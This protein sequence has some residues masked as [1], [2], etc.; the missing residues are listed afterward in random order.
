MEALKNVIDISTNKK[1]EMIFLSMED[2]V[3]LG[4]GKV[5]LAAH[6]IE[7]GFFLLDKNLILQPFKTTLKPA[8]K[9]H[10]HHQG[11]VNFLPAY[12][13][14]PE[15]E[16]YGCKALG[17]MPSNVG[18]GIP[19]ATGVICL[20]DPA[21][22]TPICVMDAQVISATRTGAVSMLAA[23]KLVP[24][25]VEEVGLVGAGVNMKTQLMGLKHALPN[26][27]RAYVHSRG[28]SKYNF[29]TSMSIK[30]EMDVIPMESAKETVRNKRV[31]VTCLPN[32]SSPVVKDEWIME[33]GVT[34]FNIGCYESEVTLLRR[35]DRIIA[36][37]W[38]QGKHRGVQ[39]HAMAVKEGIISENKI[40]DFAPIVTGRVPGRISADEN[41]FFNPTGLGFEDMVVA[42]RVYHEALKKGT[43]VKLPLWQNTDWI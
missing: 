26:L 27:K 25:D 42:N 34:Q 7:K 9:G 12:I 37:M 4:G 8:Y 6:D 41:I 29:A 11:L 31:V 17:A 32:I 18:K 2:V 20:F 10:E 33:K 28:E 22:K 19:R 43:G 13:D 40:E 30:L 39:T 36:D 5:D 14:D 3:A 38:A 24:Q 16:V 15:M 23:K 35:M 1:H 21:D